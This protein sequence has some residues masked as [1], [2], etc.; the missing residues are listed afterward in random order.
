MKRIYNIC[1]NCKD[2]NI[3][4]SMFANHYFCNFIQPETNLVIGL[5]WNNSGVDIQYLEKLELPIECKYK[6]EHIVLN[7]NND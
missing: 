2:F 6:M 3:N 5:K 4:A 1:K 7:K